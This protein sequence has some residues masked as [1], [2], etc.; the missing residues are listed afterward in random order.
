MPSNHLILCHLLVPLS[1]IFT[2][3]RVFSSESALCN[4][5]TKYWSFSFST[6][7]FQWISSVQEL[8]HVWP[9]ATPWTAACQASLSIT[10]SQS[11]LKLMSVELVT[12]SN[13]LIFCHPLLLPSSI[14]PSIRLFSNE[15]VLRIRW[16]KYWNFSFSISPSNEHSGLIS[17]RMYWMDLFAV[18]G[19]LKSLLQHHS[20]KASIFQHSVFFIVQLS[21]PYMITGKTIALIMG[22]FVTKALSLLFNILSRCVIAILP[23]SKCL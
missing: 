2:R 12:P 9:F 4:K 11:L 13:H 6:L 17:F 14:F 15:S 21:H 23:R 1:L 22:T 20:S 7:S 8:S 5:W 19:S 10:N 3:I 16:S 18:Q